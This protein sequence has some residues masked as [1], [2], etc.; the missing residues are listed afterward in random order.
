MGDTPL[1]TGGQVIPRGDFRKNTAGGFTSTDESLRIRGIICLRKSSPRITIEVTPSPMRPPIFFGQPL[2]VVARLEYVLSRSP[3]SAPA[4]LSVSGKG[5]PSAKTLTAEPATR[6]DRTT[7]LM[8]KHFKS[9]GYRNILDFQTRHCAISGVAGE[10]VLCPPR[11]LISSR[12][13]Q[14][15][16]QHSLPKWK[17]RAVPQHQ[18]QPSTKPIQAST[19]E[20]REHLLSV[21]KD[22][23][24]ES[25]A[26]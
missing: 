13:R 12:F 22:S 18:P 24:T 8:G 17:I 26:N 14:I 19:R 5:S 2:N 16:A 4:T 9:S 15:P 20:R 25:S 6:L 10:L 21:R 1:D 3:T 11:T 7:H 23:L